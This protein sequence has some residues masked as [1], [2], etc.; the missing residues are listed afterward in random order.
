MPRRTDSF[1]IAAEHA[2]QQLDA[3][4]QDMNQPR[5]PHP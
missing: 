3:M 4:P 1:F 2:P 5:A